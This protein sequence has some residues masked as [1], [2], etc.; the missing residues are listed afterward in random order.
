MYTSKQDAEA[1]KKEAT[2]AVNKFMETIC[3][4]NNVIALVQTLRQHRKREDGTWQSI[5]A[6]EVR[7]LA[8]SVAKEFNRRVYGTIYTRYK[9]QMPMLW[10]HEGQQKFKRHHLNLTV[11]LPKWLP[12]TDAIEILNTCFDSKSWSK[13]QRRTQK[14]SWSPK[15]WASYTLK[16]HESIILD[17]CHFT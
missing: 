16:E 2:W 8:L 9:R 10:S 14:I 13:K 17:A 6:S 5:N 15:N 11:V 7:K 1:F 12:V 4:E 3:D